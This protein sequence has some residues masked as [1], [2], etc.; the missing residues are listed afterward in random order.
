MVCLRVGSH[1]KSMCKML[2]PSR[3]EQLLFGSQEA[4]VCM[5]VCECVCVYVCACVCVCV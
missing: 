2:R 1:L 3:R 4:L 5:C